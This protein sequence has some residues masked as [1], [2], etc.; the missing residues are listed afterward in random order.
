MTH[1]SPKSTLPIGQ[2]NKSMDFNCQYCFEMAKLEVIQH[3]QT[4]ENVISWSATC[5]HTECEEQ[6]ALDFDMGKAMA[7]GEL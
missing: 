4:G 6:A 1:H 7:K 5:G 3:W 2:M